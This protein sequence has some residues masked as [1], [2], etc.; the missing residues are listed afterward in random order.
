[1]I[2]I[3]EWMKRVKKEFYRTNIAER[4]VMVIAALMIVTTIC[5]VSSVFI[6]LQKQLVATT[7][8]SA[9]KDL[10]M[11]LEKMDMFFQGVEND[12]VSVLLGESCQTLLE[13]SGQFL[14]GDIVKQHEKYVLIQQVINSYIGQKSSYSAITFYDLKGNY[15]ANEDLVEEE[16]Y[17]QNQMARVEKFIESDKKSEL[18]ELHKSPWKQSKAKSYADCISYV[19]KVYSMGSGRLI[20]VVEIE[21]P[22]REL[23]RLYETVMS[24]GI[25]MYFERDNHI[26]LAGDEA[27]LYQSLEDR[28]WYKAAGAQ[29]PDEDGFTMAQD[30]G[31]WYFMKE[32]KGQNWTAVSEVSKSIYLTSVTVYAVTMVLLGVAVFLGSLVLVKFLVKS[33][34]RPLSQI[35]QTIVE[36]GKGDYHKRVAVK[37]GGELG[38]LAFEFNRMVDKTEILL[39]EIVEKEED[40]RESELSLIQMQMTPHFFYNILESICGLIVMDEKK[41]A[42]HTIQLLS[43]FYRGVLNKGKEI[44]TVKQELDIASNYLEIMKVCYPG[45]FTYEVTCQ[46]ELE[47]HF[48]CKLT[49]QPI[50]EN[51]IHHGFQEMSGGGLLSIRVFAGE[52][53]MVIEVE[54]NGMGMDDKTRKSILSGESRGFRMESFGLRNTDERIKLYF[55]SRYGLKILPLAQGTKIRIF[56]P[57][58]EDYT[59]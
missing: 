28:R 22:N 9:K 50:L 11:V 42:I 25:K 44:I 23:S 30:K 13:N 33:I 58:R 26:I 35:T 18:L 32:Y 24:D 15:Y 7:S 12:A 52:R 1:M 19:R 14:Q 27:L 51:A 5:F 45:K 43:G 3:K 20:G 59:S 4:I 34:T 48:I 39:L 21:I 38:T 55:G 17:L 8:T 56:L 10:E 6:I 31:A 29:S 46:P 36:I 37:D 47:N 40:K 49:L 57:T 16:E 2:H 54:D 41:L 53:G